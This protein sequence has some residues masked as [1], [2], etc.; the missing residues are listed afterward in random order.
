MNP[1]NHMEKQALYRLWKEEE[2]ATFTGWDF[3]HLNGRCQ[4]GEI[5]WDYEAMA[6]SLLRP[7]RE[8]LDM[9]T[10][11]GEFLLTLGHPGEHT[12]VTEGYPPNVQLC[13]QRL[14]P[15]GIRVV[16]ACGEN[17]LPLESESFDVILNRHE[18]FRAEEVFRLL[19]PG[20]VF[21]TQQVG[22]QNDND[23]SRV[24]IPNFVPQYPHHTLAYNRHLLEKA[25]LTV[26][27]A[28]EHFSPIRFFD[29]GALVY[30]AKILPWEF[31]GFTVDGC[32]ETLFRLEEQRRCN[33]FIQGTEHLFLL[34]AEKPISISI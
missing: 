25:G 13:R 6:H 12:T 16:E 27:E 8:L 4:D 30:F 23:L 3:S 21:L 14:E 34:Q 31:P 20:G 18:D 7:E 11:G 9:G 17:Q 10:G 33:G 19:K 26:Q 5:P 29:V 28:R 24:L 32:L 2:A 22:G 1:L 15:L